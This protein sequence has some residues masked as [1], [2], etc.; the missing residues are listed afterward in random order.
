MKKPLRYQYT[1]IP[2]TLGEHIRKKRIESGHLQ[3]EVAALFGISEDSLTYWE[4]H[5][6]KPQVKHYPAI[7]AYLGYY[8]FDHETETLAGKLKQIRYMNGYCFGQFADEF[9]VSVDAAKRWEKGKPILNPKFRALIQTI[10]EQLQL[11]SSTLFLQEA[12]DI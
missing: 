11:P 10:W 6:T 12:L 4:N 2:Q 5:R 3:R 9:K 7:I 8:P 1:S